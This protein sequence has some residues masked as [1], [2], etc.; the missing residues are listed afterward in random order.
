M[1]YFS[2]LKSSI[3]FFGQEQEIFTKLM[4]AQINKNIIT[5]NKVTTSQSDNP[6]SN[7]MKRER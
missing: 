7:N 5:S 2:F 1:I 4:V 6:T 3:L